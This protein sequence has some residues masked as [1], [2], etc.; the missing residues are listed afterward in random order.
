ME[1]ELI[2]FET[3]KLAK[4]KGFLLHTIDVFYQYDGTK[5]L[6]H[7][8]SKRALQVQDMD[9]P[10]CYAPTQSLLQKFLWEEHSIWAESRPLFSANEQIGI[11]LSIT[12]WKFS[13]ILIEEDD[14]F[15][16]YKGFEKVLQEALKLIKSK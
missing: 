2:K 15:D 3:A 12:S 16:V 1:D 4:E 9:R 14:E 7:R 11:Y 13:P 5:S 10:E 6:C 8:N